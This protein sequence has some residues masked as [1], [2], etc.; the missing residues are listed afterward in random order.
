LIFYYDGHGSHE[1]VLEM[2]Q[3]YGLAYTKNLTEV[4]RRQCEDKEIKKINLQG[5]AKERA[6]ALFGT[7]GLTTGQGGCGII[8]RE[9][10]R[11]SARKL[12]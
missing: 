10:L 3:P 2:D 6:N 7:G 12:Q 11:E 8:G 1:E 5:L 9:D 4:I